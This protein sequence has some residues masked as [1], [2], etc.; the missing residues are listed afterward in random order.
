MPEVNYFRLK[1]ASI[2]AMT[3]ITFIPSEFELILG[4]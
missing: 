1:P 4:N 2:Q 3:F